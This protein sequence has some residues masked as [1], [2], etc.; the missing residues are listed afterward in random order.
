MK[1]E[2]NTDITVRYGENAQMIDSTVIIPKGYSPDEEYQILLHE[3]C[4]YRS[5][6]NFKLWAAL[7]V[8]CL[9]RASARQTIEPVSAENFD[10]RLSAPRTRDSA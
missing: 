5:R 9:E 8:V 1:M 6:D 3:L 2:I 7:A 10:V 4:H